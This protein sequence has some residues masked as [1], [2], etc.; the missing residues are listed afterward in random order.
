[1]QT[2]QSETLI[3]DERVIASKWTLPPGSGTGQHTHELDYVVVYLTDGVLT[4]T[5]DGEEI[6]AK[7]SKDMT[8]SRPAGVSHNVMNRSDESIAFIEIELKRG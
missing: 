7:V 6:E 5:S 4:V 1:M 2:A 3:D 8:T